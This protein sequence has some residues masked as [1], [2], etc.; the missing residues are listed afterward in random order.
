MSSL[1]LCGDVTDGEDG[2]LGEEHESDG[3]CEQHHRARLVRGGEVH[4]H[5][6]EQRGDT[7]RGLHGGGAGSDVCGGGDLG[8]RRGVEAAAQRGD[9]SDRPSGDGEAAVDELHGDAV[10]EDVLPGG[11]H[12]GVDDVVGDPLAAHHGEL[13]VHEASLVARDERAGRGGEEGHGGEGVCERGG[14]VA[15]QVVLRLDA[16]VAQVGGDAAVAGAEAQD[17]EQR[18]ERERGDEVGG[19]APR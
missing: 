8:Q 6:H 17:A 2:V 15:G 7:Q 13:V 5:G 9:H 1:E 3:A 14:V 19:E 16:R 4:G 11:V 18:E 10:L 12:V